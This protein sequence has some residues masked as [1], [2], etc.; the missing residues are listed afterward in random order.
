M[1]HGNRLRCRLRTSLLINR[2]PQSDEKPPLIFLPI[3]EQNQ[4]R[5]FDCCI[6]RFLASNREIENEMVLRCDLH[7]RQKPAFFRLKL[8]M[9]HTH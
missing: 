2:Y 9:R 5:I 1:L 4:E 7:W 6:R 3:H 8:S